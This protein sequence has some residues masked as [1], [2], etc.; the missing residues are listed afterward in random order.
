MFILTTRNI[1]FYVDDRLFFRP[2]LKSVERAIP[3][4]MDTKKR[5]YYFVLEN[6]GDILNDLVFNF[7]ATKYGNFKLTETQLIDHITD[8]FLVYRII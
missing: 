6:R 8:F 7:A 2:V 4:S 1:L 5:E 3:E